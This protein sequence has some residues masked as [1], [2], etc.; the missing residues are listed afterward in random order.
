MADLVTAVRA[1]PVGGVLEVV[2]SGGLAREVR[3][4]LCPRDG[5]GRSAGPDEGRPDEPADHEREEH[6]RP[7]S[8]RRGHTVVDHRVH[9]VNSAGPNAR[10][11]GA[12]Q[13]EDRKKRTRLLVYEPKPVGGRASARAMR[14][15]TAATI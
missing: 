14:S 6:E 11:L 1:G 5:G 13:Q 9:I 3:A 12:K 15:R 2:V 8:Q 4:G 7:G 10:D